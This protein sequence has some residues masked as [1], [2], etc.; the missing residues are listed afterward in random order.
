MSRQSKLANIVYAAELA[1]RYPEITAVST[2]PG[3]VN[4]GL[5]TSLSC[6]DKALVVVP[7]FL[8]G[9]KTISPEQGCLNQLWASAGTPKESLVNG[10]FY[11]PVG[12]MANKELSKVASS[13]SFASKLW[14]WTGAVLSKI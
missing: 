13:E 8:M 5:T 14:E 10:A 2:H 1:R 12:V 11:L 4:T 3:I 6:I 9:V 7:N